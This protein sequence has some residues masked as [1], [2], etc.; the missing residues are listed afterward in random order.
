[1]TDGIDALLAELRTTA[2]AA[3]ESLHVR[4]DAIAARE[5]AQ[6]L[7]LRDRFQLRRL[8][9]IAAPAA[10]ALMLGVALT[11]GLTTGG[12]DTDSA[13]RLKAKS[14]VHGAANTPAPR[15]PVYGAATTPDQRYGESQD[16]NRRMLAPITLEAGAASGGGVLKD[17]TA[18]QPAKERAQDYRAALTVRV[19]S[20]SRLSDATKEVLRA[21]RSWG[22]YVVS[23]NYAVPGKD[24]DSTL[25]VRIPV[26]HVQAAIQRFS[27]LGTLAAQDVSIRDVQGQINSYTRQLMTIRERIAKIRAKLTRPDLT[28]GQRASLELQLARAQRAAAAL[29]A[30]RAKLARTASFATISLTLTTREA[31]AAQ[32]HDSRAE[33]TLRDAGSILLLELAFGLFGLIVAAPI[34]LLAA[35]AWLAARVARR[36]ADDRLL[37]RA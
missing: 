12:T 19:R 4:V 20:L 9:L 14:A 27:S 17:A 28:P 30:E 21:T 3:P 32:H 15:T 18:P 24:G 5:P 33:R 25:T 16:S 29:R 6:P 35:L 1:M 11:H 13:V 37:G 36:R 22:G 2:P 8:V 7:R 26:Q 23:A 10:F 34:A 31:A